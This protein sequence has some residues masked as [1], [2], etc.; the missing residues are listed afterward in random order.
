M[1]SRQT[2]R[3]QHGADIPLISLYFRFWPNPVMNF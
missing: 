1:E 2:V 3:N